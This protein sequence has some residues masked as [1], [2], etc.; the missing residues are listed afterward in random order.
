MPPNLPAD[1]TILAGCR[2]QTGGDSF[3]AWW[4]Q[5]SFGTNVTPKLRGSVSQHFQN[6]SGWQTIDITHDKN[7]SS[8]TFRCYA[9]CV[10][11]HARVVLLTHSTNSVWWVRAGVR[12]DCYLP[13]L[14]TITEAAEERKWIEA[15]SIIIKRWEA[16]VGCSISSSLQIY[17]SKETR[18]WCDHIY[19]GSCKKNNRGIPE[20]SYFLFTDVMTFRGLDID[21]LQSMKERLGLIN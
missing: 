1:R 21:L 10:Y 2:L 4:P 6:G 3:S 9:L 15:S 14:L 12:N 17:C 18:K 5:G 19:Q 11:V 20:A 8:V 7:K 16:C 13:C